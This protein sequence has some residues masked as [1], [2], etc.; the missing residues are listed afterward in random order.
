MKGITLTLAQVSENT[1]N[2]QYGLKG[3]AEFDTSSLPIV[4]QAMIHKPIGF[5]KDSVLYGLS[6]LKNA[7]FKPKSPEIVRRPYQTRQ[8]GEPSPAEQYMDSLGGAFHDP[9]QRILPISR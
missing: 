4:A 5:A 9:S 1:L 8:N 6:K 3:H 7:I 2:L